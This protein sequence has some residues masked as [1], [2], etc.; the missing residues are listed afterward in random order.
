[1]AAKSGFFTTT[2]TTT[3]PQAALTLMKSALFSVDPATSPDTALASTSARGTLSQSTYSTILNSV[4]I[5]AV[6]VVVVDVDGDADG[7]DAASVVTD[8]SVFSSVDGVLI[9]GAVVVVVVVVLIVF[10]VLVVVVVDSA[11]V[12]SSVALM[13]RGDMK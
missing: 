10:V 5:T 9:V 12:V 8:E 1:M 6:V 7:V 11:A 3:L 4:G 13:H 2:V